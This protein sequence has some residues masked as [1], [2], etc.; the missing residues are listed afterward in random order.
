M[1]EVVGGQAQEEAVVATRRQRWPG[2]YLVEPDVSWGA[3]VVV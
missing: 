1:P 3:A 2:L